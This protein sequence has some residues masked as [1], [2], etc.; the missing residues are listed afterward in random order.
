MVDHPAVDR[1]VE[2]DPTQTFDALGIAQDVE[3]VVG[4]A[5]DGGVE[6]PAAEVVDR[7]DLAGFHLG[8]GGVVDRCGLWFGQRHRWFDLG[9]PDGLPQQFVLVRAPVRGVADGDQLRFLTLELG[10]LVV[11]PAEQLRREL[12]GREGHAVEQQ[13]C[14]IAE[15]ALELLGDAARIGG[16]S[17]L[18]CD[19]GEELVV[20]DPDDRGHRSTPIAD[21][22]HLG[23]A[24]ADDG[25]SS[26]RRAEIDS[27]SVTHPW[28]S[29]ARR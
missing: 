13:R 10:D 19:S 16:S 23:A 26:E 17:S 7:D 12:F 2:V 6:G 27:E 14:G 1:G 22:G 29:S 3:A 9:D 4:L 25:G 28:S 8:I 11:D 15:P 5:E 24:V 18:S 21:R 20:V